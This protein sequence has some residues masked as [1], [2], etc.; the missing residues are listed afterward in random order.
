[1]V[2]WMRITGAERPEWVEVRWVLAHD[3]AF[4]KIAASGS[5]TPSVPVLTAPVPSRRATPQKLR[6]N[7]DMKHLLAELKTKST[8]ATDR[9][10]SALRLGSRQ[11]CARCGSTRAGGD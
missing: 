7:R 10:T 4:T 8:T 2:L 3:A 6:G 9:R 11:G 1:M 5:E